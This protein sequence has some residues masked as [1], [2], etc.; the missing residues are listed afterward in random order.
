VRISDCFGPAGPVVVQFP[1]HAP[2]KRYTAL[3]EEILSARKYTVVRT[4]LEAMLK[5][6]VSSG[7]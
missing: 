6:P 3:V 1:N 2:G 5:R 4:E 7:S